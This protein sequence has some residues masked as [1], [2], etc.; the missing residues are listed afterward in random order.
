MATPF[1]SVMRPV[2][3]P[4]A[5]V[6]PWLKQLVTSLTV[7]VTV[8]SAVVKNALYFRYRFPFTRLLIVAG[9]VVKKVAAVP[10][11]PIKLNTPA[12]SL[13]PAIWNLSVVFAG[14]VAFYDSEVQRANSPGG[15]LAS[16]APETRFP[17]AAKPLFMRTLKPM[18]LLVRLIP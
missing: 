4:F 7:G 15:G 13:L 18:S 12:G 11:G 8:L 16:F 10:S 17:D 5:A 9:L 1:E 6:G 14:T 2:T 3:K